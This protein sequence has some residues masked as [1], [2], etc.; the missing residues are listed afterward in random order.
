MPRRRLR[1]ALA[2]A[3]LGVAL[4]A[5]PAQ[6]TTETSDHVST[7]PAGGNGALDAFLVA[8]SSDG[9]RAILSTEESLTSGDT[10]AKV[11]LYEHFNG[12][13]T[14]LSTGSAGGNGAHD[15]VFGGISA[16]ATSVF[17]ETKEQ[18]VAADTDSAYDVYKRS[19]GTTTLVTSGAINGNGGHDAFFRGNS[20]NGAEVFFETTEQLAAADTDSQLDVYQNEGATTLVSTGSAGGNGGHAAAYAGASTDG[21][22]I[23]FDTTE[24]LE[25]NDTDAALDVYQRATGATALVSTGPAG[26]NGA[27]DA[28]FAGS[29]DGGG[30]VF[31]HTDESLVAGD[32]DSRFDIYER[33]GSS[34]VLH[35]LGPSGGNSNSH[36]AFLR[37]TSADGSRVFFETSEALVAGDTDTVNDVYERSGITTSLVSTGSTSGVGVFPALYAGSSEDGLRVFFESHE[38]L[39]VADTDTQTDVYERSGGTTSLVSVGATG[40]NGPLP[41][42]FSGASSDG[43]RVF[44]MTDEQLYGA[45]TDAFSDVYERWGGGTTLVSRSATAG[46]GSFYA[47][48]AANSTDGAR[49]FVHTDEKLAS[50]DSDSNIDVYASVSSG[51]VR[52]AGASPMRLSLVP[53]F[54]A[55]SSPNRE[56]GVPDLP[57]GSNPD[58][59]CYPPVHGSSHVTISTPEVNGTGPGMV[60]VVKV[61]TM[62][63]NPAAPPDEADASVD[64]SIKDVRQNVSGIP[65]YTGQLQLETT[66]R[67][68]DKDNGVA[69]NATMQDTPFRVTIPCTPTAG[70]IGSTCSVGTTA[71]AVLGAGAIKEG[72][73]TIW[74]FGQMRI[75]DGGADGVAATTPNEPFAVQGVFVP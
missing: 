14:L 38:P 25:A 3:L 71:E 23:F 15:V 57:G 16:S 4:A 11:D 1:T 75:N 59:S 53:A 51:Y 24:S 29:S 6:G 27:V 13:T 45:D 12:V 64:V 41:A 56:H 19:A 30:K 48:F 17:F 49:V 28:F 21:E 46:N 55:C 43:A 69:A 67:V 22:T 50:S 8:A 74:Q 18:L 33:D 63:G 20:E 68:T 2:L 5:A 42:S 54:N 52:P 32:T 58:G 26:G 34:T 72:K 73:R 35:S 47:D 66:L 60:A 40:G 70:S 62:S 37:D 44:L 9:T 10:D 7:G 39:V 31:F 65:D 61:K 36:D